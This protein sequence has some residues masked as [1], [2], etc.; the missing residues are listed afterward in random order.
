MGYPPV[1][2][3]ATRSAAFTE[4]VVIFATNPG[5]HRLETG[6]L[7]LKVLQSVMEN[8]YFGVLLPNH[9]AKVATLTKS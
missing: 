2:E 8:V 5:H 1:M 7:V 6:Q 3:M 4:V 9:L